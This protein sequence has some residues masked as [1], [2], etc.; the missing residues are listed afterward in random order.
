M[1]SSLADT[2]METPRLIRF[3][4]RIENEIFDTIM[5]VFIADSYEL[6]CR[7]SPGRSLNRGV[8]SQ[9]ILPLANRIRSAQARVWISVITFSILTPKGN[10]RNSRQRRLQKRNL[11]FQSVFCYCLQ[12]NLMGGR[13]PSYT[14]HIC[15][16]PLSGFSVLCLIL[17]P[18]GRCSKQL[19]IL[20]YIDI[21]LYIFF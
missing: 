5:C 16:Y 11:I 6:P 3:N 17:P 10:V 8:G 9:G 13:L 20:F 14:H 2:V 18:G 4:F 19:D 1:K 15:G 7:E 21:Y 12:W